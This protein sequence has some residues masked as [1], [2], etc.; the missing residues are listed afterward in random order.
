MLYA[1]AVDLW[2]HEDALMK[3]FGL[4]VKARV[5]FQVLGGLNEDCIEKL[6]VIRVYR[7]VCVQKIVASINFFL[8]DFSG[9]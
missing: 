2:M 6:V 5:Y 9:I 4:P 8:E 3:N 7:H 1:G